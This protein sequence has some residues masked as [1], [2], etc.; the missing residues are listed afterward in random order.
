MAEAITA[1]S[2]GSKLLAKLLSFAWER[3]SKAAGCSSGLFKGFSKG[4]PLLKPFPL[5]I[6]MEKTGLMCCFKI[7]AA[8]PPQ[9]LAR[10]GKN[11][12]LLI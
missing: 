10:R 3:K 9:L 4:K 8:F 1:L 5:I 7:L 11:D 2:R 6:L 12:K